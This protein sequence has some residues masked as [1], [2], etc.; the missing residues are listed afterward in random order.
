MAC[1]YLIDFSPAARP[2]ARPGLRSY[3]RGPVCCKAVALAR[4]WAGRPE[5]WGLRHPPPGRE[6][7]PLAAVRTRIRGLEAAALKRL[8][9]HMRS[10]V[11]RAKVLE[12]E[13]VRRLF[14]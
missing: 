7:I 5:D 2:W 13:R 10:K 11:D 9:D 12:L 14:V 4:D 6:F 3:A 8:E 1:S